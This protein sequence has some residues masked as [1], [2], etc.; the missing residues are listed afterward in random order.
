MGSIKLEIDE[1]V[2]ILRLNNGITNAINLQLVNGLIEE[3]SKLRENNDINGLV[4]TSSNNKFFSI[5]LDIPTLYNLSKNEFTIFYRSFNQLSLDLFKFPKPTIAAITGHAIAGG[6]ILALCCDFRYIAEGRKL[7]GLNEV[8]LGVPVP[9]PADCILRQIVGPRVAREITY[10]GDFYKPDQLLQLGI[11]DQVLPEDRVILKATE[12]A[13]LL[14]A[15]SNDAFRMIKQN[16]IEL[17]MKQIQDS[18]NGKENYFIDCW[19]CD[20][21]R[22]NLRKAMQN[23]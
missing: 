11:V 2:A 14:G 10:S 17:V 5:G 22:G 19:Y 21:V 15:Y 20:E 7:M 23:F 1:K 9:F 8:K 12:K 4:M 16:H 3:L 13:K 18:L 6:C